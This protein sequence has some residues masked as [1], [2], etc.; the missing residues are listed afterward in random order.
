MVNENQTPMQAEEVN[1]DAVNGNTVKEE[2]KTASEDKTK[3]V[4]ELIDKVKNDSNMA[5]NS[6]MDTLAILVMRFVEENSELQNEANMVKDQMKKH[7]EAKDAIKALNEFLKKQIELV[8][9][10][11]ALRL[12]EEQK[13]KECKWSNGRPN[14]ADGE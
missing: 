14:A 4:Q 9:Q 12:E 13:L 1:K 7:K 5:N 11:S 6:K 3:T 8:K 10:E 2:A